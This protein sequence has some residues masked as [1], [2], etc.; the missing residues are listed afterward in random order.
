MAQA[1]VRI[2]SVFGREGTACIM[3]CT[4]QFWGADVPETLDGQPVSLDVFPPMNYSLGEL[5][6]H[7]VTAVLA[8]ASELGLTIINNDVNLPSYE[9]G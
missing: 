2:E 6:E 1:L 7:I 4:C 3:V 8:K 9:T 5:K